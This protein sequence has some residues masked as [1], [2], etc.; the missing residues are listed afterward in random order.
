MN[1]TEA[2]MDISIRPSAKLVLLDLLPIEVFLVSISTFKFE[3]LLQFQEV[4]R[5]ILRGL[6]SC[7]FHFTLAFSSLVFLREGSFRLAISNSKILS[8]IESIEIVCCVF[9][10]EG[11]VQVKYL[12]LHKFRV[13]FYFQDEKGINQTFIN[14]SFYFHF[15]FWKAFFSFLK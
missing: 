5:L 13:F 1:C 14:E 15:F 10:A 4:W 2:W 7:F 9:D 8:I 12:L 6:Y 3:N 11:K